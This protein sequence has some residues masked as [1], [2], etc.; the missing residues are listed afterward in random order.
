MKKEKVTIYPDQ[1]CGSCKF[2]KQGEHGFFCSHPK[3]ADKD[4][5][6]YTY[7]SFGTTC[8]LFEHS[9]PIS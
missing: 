2:I 9:K 5:Q 3:Q 6:E 7:W 1:N 8:E 4:L